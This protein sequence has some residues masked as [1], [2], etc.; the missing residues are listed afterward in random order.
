MVCSARLQDGKDDNQ[1]VFTFA[2][3]F[4]AFRG[5]EG[6]GEASGRVGEVGNGEEDA[7]GGGGGGEAR[8]GADNWYLLPPLGTVD[9]RFSSYQ[10]GSVRAGRGVLAGWPGGE[11]APAQQAGT[12]TL[13][14]PVLCSL[15][16]LLS[17]VLVIV[18]VSAVLSRGRTLFGP[19]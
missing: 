3:P 9:T 16:L 14:W 10:P 6:A 1:P 7:Q 12:N 5:L 11:K 4:M 8:R 15:L 13:L 17:F 18:V 19:V 2:S